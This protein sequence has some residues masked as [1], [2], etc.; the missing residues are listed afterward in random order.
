MNSD[1]NDLLSTNVF[2]REP[3]VN[4]NVPKDSIDEFRKYYEN[5]VEKE[6][7]I[8]LN[9][10]V[11]LDEQSDSTNLLSTNLF[12][13]VDVKSPEF[14]RSMR[15]IKTLVSIDSRDR[16]KITY[17]KPNKF[18]IY[19]GKDFLNVRTIKL[20]SV[21]FPNTDAVI[22]S[23][24]NYVYWRNEEDI[25]NDFTS[26]KDNNITYP[27]YNTELRI[28]SYI[29][30]TL[31][32]EMMS[33][34]NHTRRKQ[35][36]SN[37]N[38]F[39][40][41]YHYFVISLDI[42]TDIVTFTSLI[43][44]QL[45]NNPFATTQ[46]SGVILVNSPSHGLDNNAQIYI[47]GSNSISGIDSGIINTFHYITKINL[48]SFTIEVNVNSAATVVGGGNLVKSGILAPF[49]LLWGQENNTIAQNIGYPL[50][51]SSTLIYTNINNLNNVFQMVISTTILHNIKKTYDYIGKLVKIGYFNNFNTFIVY[52]TYLIFDVIDI[53]NILVEISDN[54]IPDSL[55]DNIQALYI[56]F[57]LLDAIPV[58]LYSNYIQSSFMVTT[59]TPHGYNLL[60]ITKRITLY[61]T[62]DPSVPNDTNYD[63]SYNILQVPSANTIILP[64]SLANINIHSSGLYG[65]I[66]SLDILKTHTVNISNIYPNFYT[67]GLFKFTKISCVSNHNLLTGDSVVF[68]NIISTPIL[69][70]SYKISSIID[71]FSFYIQLDMTALNTD[72]IINGTSFIGT[73]LV[74]MTFPKHS[75]NKILNIS[76]GSNGVVIIQTIVN[77]NFISGNKMRIMD[78]TTSPSI[79]GG[80]Y[81][82]TYIS[83]DTFSITR[84]PIPFTTL[85]IPTIITGIIGMSNDFFL[86]GLTSNTNI[87]G[88]ILI[89][90]LNGVQFKVRDVININTFTFMVTNSFS[91]T[92]TIGGGNNI[93]ISSLK[94]GYSGIQTNT[95]NKLLNRS[96]NLEG[97]NYTFLTCPQLNTMKNTGNVDNIFARISLNQAPGYICFDFLS[98]PKQF[99]TV[100]LDKLSELEFSV[101]NYN[102]T[103]YEFNDLDYSFCLEITEVI[104]S[105]EQFNHSSRR[106]IIDIS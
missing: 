83:E 105:I 77:H 31:K 36:E 24:N 19:L 68:Y 23:S 92:T 70:K 64:G 73:G 85:S 48:N 81:E 50:E 30:S 71:S 63:G 78:S 43:L 17:L 13:K 1:S 65:N 91:S 67:N 60:D 40:G 37:G 75:F 9:N 98:E 89:N 12:K 5:K 69:N 96:I 94:H 14:N 95:K 47:L 103:P 18:K 11:Q 88:G 79:D 45:P 84:D 80:G 4:M 62:S 76:N 86:Y 93:Y 90:D 49:Q 41:D 26:I 61:N 101:M 2:I 21:E 102:N 99:N 6:E 106:G 58:T 59:D 3:D 29:A 33:K 38:S 55:N 46:S 34:I 16:D 20:V 8:K 28:G 39:V 74:T 27:I 97:E 22:N 7:I 51:N 100:P 72:N 53:N 32:N 56:K 42:D 52:R 57:E 15:N 25:N 10:I 54:T 66:P 82:V 87:I 35:G 44:S 104:D